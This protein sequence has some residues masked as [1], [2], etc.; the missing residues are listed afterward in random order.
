MPTSAIEIAS[1]R[2]AFTEDDVWISTA[3]ECIFFKC[4]GEPVRETKSS[5]GAL[6]GRLAGQA[7]R[8][9]GTCTTGRVIRQINEH[10]GLCF[11]VHRTAHG[12]EVANHG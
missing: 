10:Q 6:P 2:T 12:C 4:A 8:R 1:M 3:L 9:Y 7:G 11:S 5:M